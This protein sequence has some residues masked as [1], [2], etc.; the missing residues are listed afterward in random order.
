M[1]FTTIIFLVILKKVLHF[2]TFCVK[3]SPVANKLQNGYKKLQNELG[4]VFIRF[5]SRL[6]ASLLLFITVFSVVIIQ[7]RSNKIEVAT[8]TVT[9][10]ASLEQDAVVEKIT[11]PNDKIKYGVVEETL[12]NHAALNPMITGDAELD[13]KVAEILDSLL[14]GSMSNYEKVLTV[15]KY[16]ETNYTYYS[17]Y[18]PSDVHYESDYDNR[19]VGRARG[20]LFSGHGTCTEYSAAFM[21]MM[22]ALGFD[23]YCVEGYFSGGQHT[24]VIMT[25][26]GKNYIF[27]PQID[28]RQWQGKGSICL[29]RFCMDESFKYYDCYRAKNEQGNID[30]FENFAIVGAYETGS[31]FRVDALE[32]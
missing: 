16:I 22:R 24:W 12:I 31:N 27:D 3:V 14:N 25:L 13:K 4:S 19:I 7:S 1:H 30:S 17:S 26:D 9:F 32:K 28:Y 21:V 2:V 15:Y 11:N 20:F 8:D 18:D 10:A 29:T 23:A 6:V 5:K